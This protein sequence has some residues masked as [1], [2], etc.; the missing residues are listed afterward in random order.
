MC[1]HGQAMVPEPG[2]LHYIPAFP[3]H[4]A[5]LPI[6]SARFFP[7]ER[8]PYGYI[9][10][11]SF[12]HPDLCDENLVELES[13]F[14]IFFAAGTAIFTIFLMGEQNAGKST[15]I[16][17]FCQQTNHLT[18]LELSSAFPSL[19]SSFCNVRFLTSD[20]SRYADEPPFLD[21]DLCRG[22]V[23]Q[24]LE[25]FAFFL[26]EHN[27]PVPQFPGFR[28]APAP[29]A[30]AASLGADQPRSIWQRMQES[31]FPSDIRYVALQFVEVGGDHLDALMAL[32]AAERPC[33][34][35]RDP[36]H[37][38]PSPQPQRPDGASASILHHSQQL[39]QRVGSVLFFIN[40]AQ[41]WADLSSPQPTGYWGRLMGRL[42]YLGS[43]GPRAASPLRVVHFVVTRLPPEC[44][45]GGALEG[46]L[47]ARAGL[48]PALLT[49]WEPQ[50]VISPELADPEGHPPSR[51][52]RLLELLLGQTL[53]TDPQ[54]GPARLRVGGVRVCN[55]VRP[56]GTLDAEEVARTLA[57]ALRLGAVEVTDATEMTAEHILQADPL[58]L[59]VVTREAFLEHLI[60]LEDGAAIG[61][62]EEADPLAATAA[63][64]TPLMA[65]QY[66]PTALRLVDWGLAAPA[67]GP[68]VFL[69][70]RS[71]NAADRWTYWELVR[72]PCA[73]DLADPT[74]I[75][76]PTSPAARGVIL[77][78]AQGHVPTHVW[79]RP[80]WAGD[81]S[82]EAQ[83]ASAALEGDLLRPQWAHILGGGGD[84][85]AGPWSR[86]WA[87][88]LDWFHLRW[89][90][91]TRAV[92]PPVSPAL[93]EDVGHPA[94]R[95]L[96]GPPPP[97]G[98]DVEA[99]LRAGRLRPRAVEGEP[100][101]GPRLLLTLP[102]PHDPPPGSSSPQ[103]AG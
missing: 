59:G 28:A 88:L 9:Q 72:P 100:E 42:R 96:E 7:I 82:E 67:R 49:Q 93:L 60:R 64:P 29:A 74:A 61:N 18:F 3:G 44:P 41:L 21:T 45:M 5:P 86:L 11:A 66:G 2:S 40:G 31:G 16:H 65:Q 81:L 94:V 91:P 85:A 68:R 23:L 54:L 10:Q 92:Q 78:F 87:G 37:G 8:R 71:S 55:H 98:L 89:V 20:A 39:L 58:P 19:S 79:L 95:W 36:Q 13:P 46:R 90:L 35:T 38:H 76:L 1:E 70:Q 51:L 101:S 27:L 12:S 69:R 24:T 103:Q 63:L 33:P 4:E 26:E 50:L 97:A 14:S 83:R 30:P 56:D 75:R 80:G 22:V 25:D 57:H 77:H 32:E 48:D 102:E 62:R 52:E 17:S 73:T 53:G 34:G 15:L 99:L 47:L 43:L 84:E 6:E